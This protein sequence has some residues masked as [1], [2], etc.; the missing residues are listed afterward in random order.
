MDK[1]LIAENFN[2]VITRENTFSEENIEKFQGGQF[3][4]QIHSIDALIS[5]YQSG[6]QIEN[7]DYTNIL[8]ISCQDVIPARAKL[9]LDTLSR[10]YIDEKLK[11]NF[12]LNQ[13]TLNFI[14]KQMVEVSQF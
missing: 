10:V 4:F 2:F 7:P 11:S 13:R 6:L 9:F 3:E 14:D 12:D 8:K 5:Q 1:E